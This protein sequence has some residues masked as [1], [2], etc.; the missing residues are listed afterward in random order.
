[1]TLKERATYSA[2][3]GDIWAILHNNKV[4]EKAKDVSHSNQKPEELN[5]QYSMILA[6]DRI[7]LSAL[8]RDSGSRRDC[9][10]L[11]FPY[12]SAKEVRFGVTL[13]IYLFVCFKNNFWIQEVGLCICPPCYCLRKSFLSLF[14]FIFIAYI[15]FITEFLP[16]LKTHSNICN[17]RIFCFPL[18]F[19]FF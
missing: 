6:T 3:L 18:F 9:I 14:A 19:F 15:S 12:P 13:F 2:F 1:M 8:S 17:C 16:I 11:P 4:K 5:C 7:V 10:I